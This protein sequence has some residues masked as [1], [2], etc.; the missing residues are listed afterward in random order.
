MGTSHQI[1][2]KPTEPFDHSII[3]LLVEKSIC[4]GPNSLNYGRLTSIACQKE[5]SEQCMQ[6]PNRFFRYSVIVNTERGKVM[7]M[8]IATNPDHTYG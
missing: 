8:D 4:H 1:N 7:E 3:K 5:I 2:A 6:R